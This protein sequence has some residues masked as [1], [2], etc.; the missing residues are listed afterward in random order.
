M[1]STSLLKKDMMRFKGLTIKQLLKVSQPAEV[2]RAS[3]IVVK[4]VKNIKTKGGHLVVK[5]DCP[6]ASRSDLTFKVWVT[7]LD[8][9]DPKQIKDTCK[10]HAQCSCERYLY[11]WEFANATHNA[12]RI[13]YGNGD[14]P[15][16]R[17]PR[18]IPGLCKHLVALVE[19]II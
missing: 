7:F 2:A 8:I 16:I 15:V 13:F 19:Q 17:N 3:D 5:A 18:Q 14:A 1:K 12:A 9:S 6:S 4:N 11:M 10:V